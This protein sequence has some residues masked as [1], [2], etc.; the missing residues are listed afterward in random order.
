MWFFHIF[1]S[2]RTGGCS[3]GGKA[4]GTWKCPLHLVPSLRITGGIPPFTRSLSCR[5]P[6]QQFT[7]LLF[8]VS[9]HYHLRMS[10]VSSVVKPKFG[11]INGEWRK[12][13]TGW[14]SS[15]DVDL[16]WAGACLE[17]RL[18]HPVSWRIFSVVF[19]SPFGQLPAAWLRP[20]RDRLISRSFHF[21]I[22]CHRGIRRFCDR[23]YWN[24]Y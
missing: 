11:W 5:A 15:R 18:W 8:Q 17:S 23:S 3:F 10:A 1:W 21:I 20:D 4:A 22:Y 12:L 14:H 19:F 6:V 7:T 2:V 16:Y 9:I 13:G 24:P